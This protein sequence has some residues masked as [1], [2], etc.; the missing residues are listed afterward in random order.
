[1]ALGAGGLVESWALRLQTPR[2][3]VVPE[4]ARPVSV[5]LFQPASCTGLGPH[6]GLCILIRAGAG[7]PGHP[8]QCSHWKSITG[9]VTSF[10]TPQAHA[11]SSEHTSRILEAS[12]LE[13]AQDRAA[14]SPPR[15]TAAV[16]P[17]RPGPHPAAHAARTPQ[18]RARP[19]PAPG[20]RQ[21]SPLGRAAPARARTQGGARAGARE[22]GGRRMQTFEIGR[23][24]V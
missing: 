15:N 9:E 1:M 21:A 3:P 19:H 22:R 14:P 6:P 12:W 7:Q 10:P 2:V 24:H 4:G 17:P 8:G 23:A 5:P 11:V 20:G 18:V 16:P 13:T